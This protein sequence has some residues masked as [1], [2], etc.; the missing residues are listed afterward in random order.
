MCDDPEGQPPVYGLSG[1]CFLALRVNRLFIVTARHVAQAESAP[2]VCV[3]AS[4]DSREFLPI[5]NGASAIAA[6]TFD[7]HYADISAFEVEQSLLSAEAAQSLADLLA[8]PLECERMTDMK[9]ST[10]LTIKGYPWEL[11]YIDYDSAQIHVQGL[12]ASGSFRGRSKLN[13]CYQLELD[14]PS[15]VRNYN[16]MSGSPVFAPGGRC[17][18]SLYAPRLAGMAILGGEGIFQ[19]IDSSIVFNFLDQL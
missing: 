17:Q 1:S 10:R 19:F 8:I 13:G 7:Y 14:D 4:G 11:N 6:N 9:E 16:L 5:K 2:R 15:I 18:A 12:L 3:L